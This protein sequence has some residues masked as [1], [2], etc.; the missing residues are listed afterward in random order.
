[1]QRE[2]KLL[3]RRVF[4]LQKIV[5]KQISKEIDLQTHLID[6]RDKERMIE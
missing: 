6:M 2:N 3:K 1:M 4:S 5:D